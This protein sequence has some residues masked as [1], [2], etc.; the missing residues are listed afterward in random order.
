[1]RTNHFM[2]HYMLF[3]ILLLS[4]CSKSIM[5]GSKPGVIGLETTYQATDSVYHESTS[6]NEQAINEQAID[7]PVEF[8][9][10]QVEDVKVNIEFRAPIPVKVK[11]SGTW[12]GP[13]SQL[14]EIKQTTDGENIAIRLLTTSEEPSCPTT[15]VMLP[16]EV[17]I[18]LNMTRKHVG[19][20][21][22]S[23]NGKETSFDWS[24]SLL[25]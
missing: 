16:F 21:T 24:G 6:H 13:C 7:E 23:V 2:I 25:K 22:V 9:E 10:I 12:P 18:P 17:D 1:M 8:Q 15:Q 20:Y 3:A 19:S 11:I 5:V 4:A 14:A